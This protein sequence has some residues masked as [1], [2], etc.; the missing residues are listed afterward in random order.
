M[1]VAVK[2]YGN[3]FAGHPFANR[4]M[5]TLF[6]VIL[7]FLFLNCKNTN[8]VNGQ[9]SL[10]E[11]GVV[12]KTVTD[13]NSWPYFL[14]HLPEKEALILDYTGRAVGNQE[15]HTAIII[16]DVGA[17]DLQ[18]C[19]DAL[20]RLRA[21]YL[22]A[23][24]RADEISFQFTSGDAFGFAA[25]CNGKMPVA[26]G[27]GVTFITSS[28]K[29]KNKASLRNYLDIVYTYAGTLS[30]AQELKDALDFSIGTVVLKAGSP[31]HCFIITDEATIEGKRV[32]KLVEGYTPAQSI[33]V[34]R[35]TEEPELGHWHRLKSGSIHTASYD[36]RTYE[37]KRFE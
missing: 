24:N 25:Y 1:A 28:P 32:F 18:Q 34:L 27:N 12:T 10:P 31:G 22:F 35:N 14:Q 23:Q 26:K 13:K 4:C 30:L 11:T 2:R 3:S 37:L 15:K 29:P 7:P 6:P 17:K 8:G 33:Y 36:F 20:I 21:E 9:L 5:K 16:Y 19:A